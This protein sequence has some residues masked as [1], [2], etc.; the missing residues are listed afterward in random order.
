MD[1]AMEIMIIHLIVFIYD[2]EEMNT[3]IQKPKGDY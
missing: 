1:R 2:E 3:V